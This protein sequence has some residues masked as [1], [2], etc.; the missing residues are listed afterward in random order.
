MLPVTKIF[1]TINAKDPKDISIGV[2]EVLVELEKPSEI[3]IEI[4]E[5][6]IVEASLSS[7]LDLTASVS[8]QN[9]VNVEILGSGPAG[10]DG[11]NAY[12]MW[13]NRGN[14]GSLDD[15]F[16]SLKGQDGV[17]YIHPETHSADMI[18]ETEGKQFMSSS[19]KTKAL[20]TFISDQQIA[21]KV[22]RVDH[23]LNKY[24]SVTVVD[25][26]DKVIVGTVEYLDMDSLEITF[27]TQNSGKAYLN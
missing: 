11:L 1:G 10:R 16:N 25:T 6:A 8:S 14:V 17:N 15:F 22:W 26:D 4:E 2:T 7:D 13:L 21:L 12:E 19:E 18:T 9:E 20:D 3:N 27:T 24:P 5:S 23:Y